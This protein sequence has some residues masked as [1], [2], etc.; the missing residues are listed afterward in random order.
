MRRGIQLPEFAD[1]GALPA[2]NR[3]MRL[4]GDRSMGKAILYRPVAHLSAVEL[5]SVVAQ[6]FG[7]S[8]AVGA[9]WRTG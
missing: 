5:E 6:D 3:G 9:R 1:L 2:T 7:S 8:E 4:F